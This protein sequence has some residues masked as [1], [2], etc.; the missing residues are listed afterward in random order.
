MS[1]K[2]CSH[3]PKNFCHYFLPIL[4]H[5]RSHFGLLRPTLAMSVPTSDFWPHL[6]HFTPHFCHLSHFQPHLRPPLRHFG[7]QLRHFG[8][9]LGHFR[10]KLGLS[11]L[12]RLSYQRVM[13]KQQS[14]ADMSFNNINGYISCVRFGRGCNNSH[15]NRKMR[16]KKKRKDV[17]DQ[18][19][20]RNDQQQTA[21]YI[22]AL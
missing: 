8:P 13:L 4:R 15:Q 7:P 2:F 10:P 14:K 22:V 20:S 17:T 21:S 16:Q 3:S 6:G 9:H 12:F 1:N 18:L 11:D 5:L 19:D